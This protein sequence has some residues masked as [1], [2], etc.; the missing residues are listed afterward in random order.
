MLSLSIP[1]AE[2][3]NLILTVPSFENIFSAIAVIS[4]IGFDMDVFPT[5]KHLCS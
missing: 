3:I 4:E 1:Y 5:A 2:E